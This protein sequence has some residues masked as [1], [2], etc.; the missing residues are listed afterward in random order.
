[1]AHFE[2]EEFT[3]N[4]KAN[5]IDGGTATG[6][7]TNIPYGTQRQLIATHA[8]FSTFIDWTDDETGGQK[9]PTDTFYLFVDKSYN[10]TAN[11]K[12][13]TCLITLIG[14]PINGGTPL[15]GGVHHKG[16][17]I[18]V[19]ANPNGCHG[20][21]YW[22]ENDEI[23][24]DENGDIIDALYTFRVMQN[25]TLM[26]HYIPV[27]L[28]IT[29]EPNDPLLGFTTGDTTNIACETVVTVNAYSYHECSFLYWYWTQTDSIVS[30]K[31]EYTFI[32]TES[33]H[34]VAY[35]SANLYDIVLIANPPDMGTATGG[36]PYPYGLEITV[37]A[38]P[39]PGYMLTNWTEDSLEVSTNPDYTFTVKNSRILVANFEEFKYIVK[40]IPNDTLYGHASGSGKYD[41]NDIVKAKAVA[42]E[43]YQFVNWTRDGVPI[44]TDNPYIFTVTENIELIA[45]FYGLDFDTYAATLWDNTF[46][47][48]LVKLEKEHYD[49][50]NCKWF[51]NGI[52]LTKTNTVD[53]F[54][55]S[56]GPNSDD[57]LE[58]APTWYMFQIK[59][60][61]GT[62]LN[63]TKKVLTEYVFYFP[64]P[65]V[66]K[67]VIYP[68][69]TTSGNMFTVEGTV[70]GTP[71][72]IYNALGICVYSAT[73]G[74]RT[75]T[76]ALNMPPGVYIVRNGNKEGKVTIAK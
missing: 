65:P 50:T 28:N 21:L 40:I 32:A 31:P 75:T 2:L 10:L 18:T 55:Y 59:L 24:R 64:A 60:R 9:S 51:K 48:N 39:Q 49:V 4:V 30:Y 12:M 71:L 63:S 47:L 42:M 38:E 7:G 53:E 72:Y 25:R 73:A 34:L 13:E 1:L 46:M 27:P 22:T 14:T 26:A 5:P 66:N 29:T 74:D 67:L 16:N 56:A 62:I 15:G 69:P 3:V 70:N 76:L 68:N 57:R 44:S 19:D 41:L 11:F 37:H 33:R 35:F 43:G 54:S 8:E 23:L 61:N 20:F 52:E 58:L 6:A 36:G 17:W 45:N